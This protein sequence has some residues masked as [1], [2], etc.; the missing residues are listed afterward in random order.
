[1]DL[2]IRGKAALVTAGS[3][4]LGRA[5]AMALAAE[6]V[7]VAL[8]A[9]NEKGLGQAAH[10]IRTET[11]ADVFT[12]TADVGQPDSLRTLIDTVVARF[13][14]IDI[15][16]ANA[17]GPPSKSFRET[18]TEDWQSAINLNL[19]STVNL[20]RAVLP[21]MCERLWGRFLTITSAS[22][23]QPIDGLVLSNSVR[24]A[25]AGLTKTLANECGP[26]NVLV[27]NLCPGYTATARLEGL[28]AGKPELRDRWLNQIPVGRF[29]KPEEFGAVAA[30]LCSEQAGYITGV[31]LAVDG[32]FTRGLL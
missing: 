4:G 21:G 16:V 9:R 29:G 24:A 11:G 3:Q 1:M 17:G 25:V 13:G 23:K 18:T 5:T 27:N 31:S 22:V 14:R 8:C 2:G 19:I 32:G 26:Y 7:H 28:A 12:Q 20:A 10:A 30:F 6:G 15:C